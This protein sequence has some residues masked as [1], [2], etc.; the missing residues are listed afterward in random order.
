[1]SNLSEIRAAIDA[2]R[3]GVVDVNG[4]RF[5]LRLPSSHAWRCAAEQHVDA[6]GRV[7]EAAAFRGLLDAALVAWDGPKLSWLL[8]GTADDKPLDFSADARALLLDTRQDI[9]DMLTLKLS[10]FHRDYMARFEANEKN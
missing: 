3:Q 9:A 5:T 6:H 4:A 2:A 1:M 7:L 10:E 8:P